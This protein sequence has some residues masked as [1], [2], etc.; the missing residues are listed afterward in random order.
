[1]PE[2]VK[3]KI[4]EFHDIY[5]D[6]DNEPFETSKTEEAANMIIEAAKMTGNEI[7]YSEINAMIADSN[8]DKDTLEDIYDII[9]LL[10]SILIEV[11]ISDHR[12]DLTVSDLISCHFCSFN[13]QVCRFFSL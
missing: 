12:V 7:T 13:Y 6:D 11:G 4:N 3:S 1:M 2:N 5:A 9:D 10:K 8:F